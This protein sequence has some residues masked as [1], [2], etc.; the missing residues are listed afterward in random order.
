MFITDFVDPL[1][2]FNN[3]FLDPVRL[4][5][6][7][8]LNARNIPLNGFFHDLQA[9]LVE[10]FTGGE[11]NAAP[12]D[13]GDRRT[14]GK[15]VVKNSQGQGIVFRQDLNFDGNLRDNP[16]RSFST[17]KDPVEIITEGG[18]GGFKTGVDDGT[19]NHDHLE[20]LDIIPCGSVFHRPVTAG[21]SGHHT[22]DGGDGLAAGVGGKHEVLFAQFRIEL[23]AN[24]A[25]FHPG[26]EVVLVD[27]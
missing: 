13:M 26:I 18:L 16:Q 11:L 8:G 6:Q 19:I 5:N 24:D 4:N 27:F 21:V 12:D 2:V 23:K 20:I 22:P 17:G 25:R 3:G 10:N 9:V 7:H 15:Q 1:H 14:C